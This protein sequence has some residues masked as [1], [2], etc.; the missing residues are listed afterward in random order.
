MA[1]FVGETKV[2]TALH[3]R[4]LTLVKIKH[5][6]EFTGIDN[7]ALLGSGSFGTVY[8]AKENDGRL[9]AVKI[10]PAQRWVDDE[11]ATQRQVMAEVNS[12]VQLEESPYIVKYCNAWGWPEKGNYL[13]ISMQFCSG[14]NLHSK[15]STNPTTKQITHWLLQLSRGVEWMHE[16]H[17]VHRDLYTQNVFID[18]DNNIRIGDFGL[19]RS[20]K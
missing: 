18:S 8:C 4:E 11:G 14:G 6:H 13:Y 20:L 9:R 2:Q 5:P 16:K 1:N 10:I 3:E 19:A 15:L 7:E 12:W 17:I